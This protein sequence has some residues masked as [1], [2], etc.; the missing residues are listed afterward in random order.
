MSDTKDDKVIQL[1]F[2]IIRRHSAVMKAMSDGIISTMML[3]LNSQIKC[4]HEECE[5]FALWKQENHYACDRHVAIS[6]LKKETSI[7]SWEELNIADEIKNIENFIDLK[8][9]ND[10]ITII[11]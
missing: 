11:H 7:D 9:N 2:E 4:G 5:K 8:K 1:M 6:I 3:A 10:L